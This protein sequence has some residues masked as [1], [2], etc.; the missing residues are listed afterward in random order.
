MFILFLKELLRKKGLSRI[1][2][3]FL[4][5][6]K[7]C[8]G[9][10]LDIGGGRALYPSH[11][12]F[13]QFESG[14]VLESAN[15]SVKAHPNYLV[16]LEKSLLPVADN[17]YDFV[18]AFNLLEHILNADQVIAEAYR[19]LKTEG[20]LIGYIPFLI[21]VHPDPH[22]YCRYTKEKLV[23]IFQQHEFKNIEILSVGRGPFV[24]AYSQLEFIFPT[25]LRIVIVPLSFCCDWFLNLIKPKINFSEM[26]PLGYLFYVKK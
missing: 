20:E 12:R 15:I 11:M 24:A 7:K 8:F 21:N 5:Q 4:L 14:S 22:D 16:D 26:Y 1:L 19:V 9:K 6:E 10:I 3:N 13:L 2:C 17:S 18:L 23:S 25:F